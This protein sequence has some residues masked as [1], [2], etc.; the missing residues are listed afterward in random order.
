MDIG[1]GVGIAGLP[2]QE[3]DDLLFGTADCLQAQVLH[4]RDMGAE[5]ILFGLR[6]F[7][8]QMLHGFSFCFT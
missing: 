2:R 1:P 4:Q 5:K 6:Q 7:G 3:G 8:L